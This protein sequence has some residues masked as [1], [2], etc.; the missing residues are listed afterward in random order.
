[1]S[2]TIELGIDAA[3]QTVHG[4]GAHQFRVG[5]NERPKV[6]RPDLFLALGDEFHVDRQVAA[7]LQPGFGAFGEGEHARLVIRR[8]AAPQPPLVDHAAVGRIGPFL[9]R[10]FRLHIIVGIG[11]QR[12]GAATAG[13]VADDAWWPLRCGISGGVE[14]IGM[15]HVHDELR[16]FLQPHVLRAD[17]LLLHETLQVGNRLCAMRVDPIECG[18]QFRMGVGHWAKSPFIGMW[19]T[20]LCTASS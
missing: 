11:E 8:A 9:H 14:A 6:D 17:A 20:V 12:L 10:L 18:L 2:G 13:H 19:Y 3:I 16:A 15:H 7:G 1:M 4:V 5:C